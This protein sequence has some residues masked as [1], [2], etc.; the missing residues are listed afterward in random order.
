MTLISGAQALYNPITGGVYPQMVKNP[1]L[2][3]VRKLLLIFMP[4]VIFGC[5]LHGYILGIL[6]NYK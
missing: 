5:F 3:I 1:S 6:L 2:R 4:C